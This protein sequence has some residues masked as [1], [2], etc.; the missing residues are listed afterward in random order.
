MNPAASRHIPLPI[1]QRSE[2]DAPDPWQNQKVV[3][4][5]L[6]YYQFQGMG[7]SSICFGIA[8]TSGSRCRILPMAFAP[9]IY[10]G[11]IAPEQ[12]PA[13]LHAVEHILRIS[14]YPPRQTFGNSGLTLILVACLPLWLASGM[15][16]EG[17]DR[18]FPQLIA[19]T[20]IALFVMGLWTLA[21]APLRRIRERRL[22]ARFRSLLYK[23]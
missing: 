7:P 3:T 2:F 15:G 16:F 21:K 5:K 19:T 12:L 18:L 9:L 17:P 22:T 10:D 1:K 14:D 11:S 6:S 8:T 20:G 13:L 23:P 4:W